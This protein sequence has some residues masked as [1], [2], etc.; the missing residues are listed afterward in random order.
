[1]AMTKTTVYLPD[2]LKSRVRQA[3]ERRG[4]S[5]AQFIRD[6]LEKSATDVRPMPT[7]GLFRGT[8]ESIDWNS[9]DHLEGFGED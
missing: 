7:F 1:M 9:N 6:S 4:V 8:G 5:E 3:A 2:D